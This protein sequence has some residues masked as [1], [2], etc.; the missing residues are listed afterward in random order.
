MTSSAAF[1]D[2]DGTLVDTHIVKYDVYSG[3]R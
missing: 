3:G 1:F 2:V